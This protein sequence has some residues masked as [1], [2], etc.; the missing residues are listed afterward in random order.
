MRPLEA[1]ELLD[2]W[3]QGLNQPPLQRALMLV[4]AASP[5]LD[6]EA[7]AG[8][9]IGARDARLLQLREWMFG[10]RLLNTAQC[11]QCTERVEWEGR[12][13]DLRIQAVDRVDLAEESALEIAGYQLHF[14]LPDSG[15]IAAVMA[16][17]QGEGDASS[18]AL[19][20][21][22]IISANHQG[23]TCDLA[24]LPQQALDALSQK[25]EQLDPQAEIR[26][27]LTCPECSHQWDVLF[28]IGGFLW[29]EINNWAERTLRTI[30]RLATAYGWTE[31]EILNLSPVRRQ[32]Y[33][34]M[35]SR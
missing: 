33:L 7:V 31:T 5:E 19:I 35:V 2:V 9:S 11:P 16:S 10:P 6:S 21:R 8:L 29:I 15:D 17:T 1:T 25:I 4:T 22:C 20:K 30:H 3:E 23:K 13:T 28:D 12:T 26:T 34:G 27:E 18:M 14:R 32:L 24:E